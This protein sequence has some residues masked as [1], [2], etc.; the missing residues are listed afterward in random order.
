MLPNYLP[1]IGS[2]LPPVSVGIAIAGRDF[3]L[4][5]AD[6]Q[7]TRDSVKRC[8]AQK[9]SRIDCVN[10]S[11]IVVQAGNETRARNVV[12]RLDLLA[13][14]AHITDCWS[15]QDLVGQAMLKVRTE[16]R[17]QRFDCSAEE[18][19][20]YFRREEQQCWFLVAHYF[21]NKPWIYTAELAGGSICKSAGNT[22]EGHFATIG[23]GGDLAQYLLTQHSTPDMDLSEATGL[24][25]Y[26]IG[27]AKKHDAYCNGQTRVVFVRC[28]GQP[29]VMPQDLIDVQAKEIERFNETDRPR[30]T[31][32]LTKVFSEIGASFV[33]VPKELF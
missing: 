24:A 21:D 2:E 29:F 32:E 8:D 30:R 23:T 19:M 26:V 3:I 10:G 17:R 16:I 11:L 20:E 5:A 18:L 6:S 28:E 7:S 22:Q 31:E 1:K 33:G 25:L 4:S 13:K 27:E 12:E 15:V 9:I 14:E